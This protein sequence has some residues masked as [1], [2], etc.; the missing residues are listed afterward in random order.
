M[1][2]CVLLSDWALQQILTT[3]TA[4]QR[5]DL[6]GCKGVSDRAFEVLDE[7]PH[8]LRALEVLNVAQCPRITDATLFALGT[9]PSLTHS[10]LP[11]LLL[12]SVC[13]SR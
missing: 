3:C 7:A 2:R 13:A 8:A 6:S 12:V 5:L 11:L 10:S 9:P 4:L 1:S